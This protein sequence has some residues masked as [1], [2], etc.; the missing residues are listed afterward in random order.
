MVGYDIPH[1]TANGPMLQ[2][3]S[4]GLSVNISK[5]VPDT[6]KYY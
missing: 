1:L 3:T 5:T 6:A 2:L 4:K